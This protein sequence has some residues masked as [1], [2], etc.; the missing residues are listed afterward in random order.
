M[1]LVLLFIG[2]REVLECGCSGAKSA[3]RVPSRMFWLVLEGILVLNLL[4]ASQGS[5][6]VVGVSGRLVFEVEVLA[7]YPW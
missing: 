1:S 2:C 3:A 5:G 6:C 7:W 4:A